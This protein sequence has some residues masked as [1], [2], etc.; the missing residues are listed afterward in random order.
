[1]SRSIDGHL[2]NPNPISWKA[3]K[4]SWQ[5]YQWTCA[6]IQIVSLLWMQ[7]ISI[8]LRR[9]YVNIHFLSCLGYSRNEHWWTCYTV[10]LFFSL[11]LRLFFATFQKN[12]KANDTSFETSNIE[13]LEWQRKIGLA[14]GKISFSLKLIWSLSW[15]KLFLQCQN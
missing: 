4:R 3:M 14:N 12:S 5:F 9:C 1:M 10:Q 8:Q 7:K 15:Q 11:K 6:F 13:P 2:L